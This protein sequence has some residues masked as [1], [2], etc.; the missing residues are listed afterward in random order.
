MKQIAYVKRPFIWSFLVLL[1]CLTLPVNA[2]EKSPQEIDLTKNNQVKTLKELVQEIESQSA[3]RFS[4]VK[5]LIDNVAVQVGK[6]KKDIDG[7][8]QEALSGTG[9]SYVIKAKDIVLMKTTPQPKAQGDNTSKIV[10]GVV[11]DAENNEP[12]IGAQIWLKET[13][14]GTVNFN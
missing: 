13:P 10:K 8:L 12:I 14:E 11:V 5:G 7:I 3:Y 1:F 4:Y 6:T 9:L 2:S